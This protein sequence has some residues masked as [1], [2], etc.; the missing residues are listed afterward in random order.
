LVGGKPLVAEMLTD[1]FHCDDRYEVESV[2]YCDDALA[3][4]ERR[5]VPP[6]PRICR[7]DGRFKRRAEIQQ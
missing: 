2:K 7:V 1:C 5:S 6:L 3:M 4:V